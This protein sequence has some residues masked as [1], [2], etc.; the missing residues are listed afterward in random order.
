MVA[1]QFIQENSRVK[2]RFQQRN[3]MEQQETN[4]N[5]IIRLQKRPQHLI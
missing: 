2:T 5:Q 4:Q 1:L 3:D